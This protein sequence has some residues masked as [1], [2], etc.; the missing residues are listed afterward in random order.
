M[1][2]HTTQVK[3]DEGAAFKGGVVKVQVFN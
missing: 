1:I 3:S 2:H